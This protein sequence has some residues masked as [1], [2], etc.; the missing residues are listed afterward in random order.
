MK[1][2]FVRHTSVAVEKGI[3]YGQTDVGLADTFPLEAA[4]V[5]D[6]L[7]DFKIDRAYTSPLSRCVKLAEACG[8]SDAVRDPRLME[9][10]FGE[11]EMKRYDEIADPRINLWY[12]DFINVKA[13][14][15]E[16]FME[17][18]QRLRSFVDSIMDSDGTI[19]VFCHGGILLNA[20][21]LYLGMT[22]HEA[23]SHQP[24]YGH[25][26]TIQL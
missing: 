14:G 13:T 3:C 20:M 19:A 21:I 23:F 6:K 16:S 15:G 11:W 18:Q 17:Q 4:I 8:F 10:D 12:E 26:L 22:Y 7:S 2:I 1:L 24:S 5:R 25:L 9:M